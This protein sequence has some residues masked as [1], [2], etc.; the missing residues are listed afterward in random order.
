VNIIS[1]HVSAE[2]EAKRFLA[3]N[4]GQCVKH[5]L[6]SRDAF[7]DFVDSLQE[8]VNEWHFF[9]PMGVYGYYLGPI[10]N[11]ETI[12]QQD[13]DDM[14]KALRIMMRWPCFMIP[15]LRTLRFGRLNGIG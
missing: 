12:G 8:E 7:L 13:W 6:V 1:Y 14:M 9:G 3:E 2:A 5:E 15:P 10:E 11:G 4:T